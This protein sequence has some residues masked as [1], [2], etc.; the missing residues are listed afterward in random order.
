MLLTWEP[1]NVPVAAVACFSGE[2][3][4]AGNCRHADME[5]LIELQG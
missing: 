3:G 2:V 1:H 5:L 4:S